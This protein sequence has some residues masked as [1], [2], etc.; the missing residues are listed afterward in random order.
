M[1]V[2]AVRP[3]DLCP[4]VLSPLRVSGRLI[5]MDRHADVTAA[6]ARLQVNAS[7]EQQRSMLRTQT[8]FPFST[9]VALQVHTTGVTRAHKYPQNTFCVLEA[10]LNEFTFQGL[11]PRQASQ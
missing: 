3:A 1:L 11:Q 7:E 4:P 9:R 2:A 8:W 5:K 6:P 10:V